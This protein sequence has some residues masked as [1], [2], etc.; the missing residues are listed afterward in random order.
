MFE[1]NRLLSIIV[2]CI[3]ASLMIIASS[4]QHIAG[5]VPID[6]T[7]TTMTTTTAT[8]A[9][10]TK[11]DLSLDLVESLQVRAEALKENSERLQQ[12]QLYIIEQIK[13]L[14]QGL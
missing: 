6:V 10:I 8:A 4:M 7:T 9:I 13:Q 2:C 12:Q 11:F 14:E 3:L 1:M 5:A